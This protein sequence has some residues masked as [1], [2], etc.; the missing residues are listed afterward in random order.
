[1]TAEGADEPLV[2]W[3]YERTPQDDATWCRH[4]VQGNLPLPAPLSISLNELHVPTGYTLVEEVIRFCIHDLRV[5]PLFDDWH[6][7]LLDSE[8]TF[9]HDFAPPTDRR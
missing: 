4:H 9:K 2:R 7:R 5:P 3:E 1:M 6:R 8:E